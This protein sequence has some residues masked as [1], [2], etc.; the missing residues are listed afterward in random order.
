[1]AQEWARAYGCAAGPGRGRLTQRSI[2]PLPLDIQ[3]KTQPGSAQTTHSLSSD[4]LL[5]V[6]SPDSDVILHS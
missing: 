2:T 6:F 3:L 5:V 1:M 4:D